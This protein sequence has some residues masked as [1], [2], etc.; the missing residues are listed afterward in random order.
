ML[1][2]LAERAAPNS[3]C[4]ADKAFAAERPASPPPQGFTTQ[5]RTTST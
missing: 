4:G 5:L 3:R 1:L 2:R